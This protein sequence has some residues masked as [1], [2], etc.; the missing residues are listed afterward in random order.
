VEDA[1][2][3]VVLAALAMGMSRLTDE[4]RRSLRSALDH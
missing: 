4:Q 3:S 2:N 1:V